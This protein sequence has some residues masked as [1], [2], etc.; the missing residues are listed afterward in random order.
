MKKIIFCLLL[1]LVAQ[2]QEGGGGSEK[3]AEAPPPA[4]NPEWMDLSTEIQTLRSK[5]KLKEDALRKL[6]TEKQE[7]S[8]PK[9]A[10]EIIKE[11]VSEHRELQKTID[12]YESKKSRLKYRYPEAGLLKEREYERIEQKTLEQ[13]ENQMGLEAH[14]QKSLIKIRKKYNR[15]DPH[16]A[17][18]STKNKEESEKQKDPNYLSAPIEMQK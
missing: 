15:P 17:K 6:I 13:M 5:I 4:K 11:M 9:R 12:A 14:A 2:S 7:T 1:T 8:D 3:K 10:Q 16:T 18:D